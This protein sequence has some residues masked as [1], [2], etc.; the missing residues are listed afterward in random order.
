MKICEVTRTV[1]ALQR[2]CLLF[3]PT[4]SLIEEPSTLAQ[5]AVTAEL[6]PCPCYTAGIHYRTHKIADGAIP[7][8][9]TRLIWT[10]YFWC[11]HLEKIAR[12]MLNNTKCKRM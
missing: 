2:I 11:K 6:A 8:S 5:I 10:Q 12:T 1:S 9:S 3:P 7:T 4:F